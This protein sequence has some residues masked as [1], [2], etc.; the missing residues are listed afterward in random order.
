MN[1]LGRI[2]VA[3]TIQG[4]HRG[5][6]VS[7]QGYRMQIPAM[8]AKYFPD[9]KC[10]DPSLDV[11][12]QLRLP[13]TRELIESLAQNPPRTISTGELPVP[14]E[15]L[16]GTF[17]ETT[18]KVEDFDL[19]IAYLPDHVPSMGTAMEM[20]AAHCAGVPVLAITD[21]IENLAIMS[22]STWVVKDLSAFH[23]WLA[24][25]AS[26]TSPVSSDIATGRLSDRP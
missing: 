13:E 26:K 21:M 6:S 25:L 12:E 2:F 9:A 11:M 19:C 14:L 17:R 16:R 23:A 18:R 10:F 20:Y 24:E 15:T 7:D 22:V 5:T 3:G 4:A 8:I 1:Q